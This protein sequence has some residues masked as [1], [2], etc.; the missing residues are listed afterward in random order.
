MFPFVISAFKFP[1][2]TT[3]FPS[4][5]CRF[6]VLLVVFLSVFL[7][8]R[9]LDDYSDQSLDEEGR[10]IFPVLL[11]TSGVNLN[12]TQI[13]ALAAL[14]SSALLTTLG[15]AALG[16]LLFSL[17]SDRDGGYSG[18]GGYGGGGGYSTYSSYRR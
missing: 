3:L 7:Q 12:I 8:V 15:L 16:F 18:S 2:A 9:A 5:M 4:K 14:L 6:Y 1:C 11:G 10:L 17:L 13:A